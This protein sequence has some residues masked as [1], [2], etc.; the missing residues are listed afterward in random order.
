MISVVVSRKAVIEK[1][2][3]HL[4]TQA[5]DAATQVDLH[6]DRWFSLMEVQAQSPLT[7]DTAQGALNRAKFLA[8][9][10]RKMGVEA[11]HF[12]D[13]NGRGMWED[14][15]IYDDTEEPY[16]KTA[17]E[18][19][20][21]ITEPYVNNVGDFV[22]CMAV[23]VRDE[24]GRVVGMLVAEHS[25]YRLWDFIEDIRVGV[26]GSA[27]M[28]GRT[29]V[30]I[31]DVD[32]ALVLSQ[33]AVREIAKTDPDY[34]ALDQL[35]R[36]AL[37]STTPGVGG[38]SWAGV[39]YLV[40]YAQIP[41]TGWGL[42]LLAEIDDF[43]D[44]IALMRRLYIALALIS[45]AVVIGISYFVSARISRPLAL[46]V[47][48][49][50]R[51]A[52]EDLGV[53]VNAIR[54]RRDEFGTLGKA[55]TEMVTQ[56]G[57]VIDEIRENSSAIS[58]VGEKM[59]ST[60]A[61]LSDGAMQEASSSEEISATVTQLLATVGANSEAAI[62]AK[63]MA[64][65][66]Q[67]SIQRVLNVSEKAN[68]SNE[69]VCRRI[70]AIEDIARQTNILALNAAVE[71]ARAGEYGRGFAVVAG[72][73]RKLAEQSHNIANEVVGIAAESSRVSSEASK[74]LELAAPEV[75]N[76]SN[77][78]QK[79]A[80]ACLEQQNGIEQISKT[81]QQL[82]KLVQSNANIS[83]ALAEASRKLLE[84]GKRL[85]GLIEYFHR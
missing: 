66:A 84:Y 82:D 19:K 25:G 49:V 58:E 85:R 2:E 71:A 15:T 76:T 51:M 38:A 9:Q 77:L 57:S 5:Q 1:V 78:V 81:I 42:I 80:H 41:S 7:L 23:P 37:A 50:E 55:L 43:L 45:L 16:F 61:E 31:A 28:V 70:G 56:L 27:Y 12:A 59:D 44:T 13:A 21:A 68:S 35:E 29:G 69:L 3:A 32:S 74:D 60:S 52:K 24:A 10:G 48:A 4:T 39:P 30:T 36:K 67:A 22:F 20:R 72:E 34:I 6:L 33:E 14:G 54:V 63:E 40:S 46:T 79:I 53:E 83:V 26:D 75:I 47:S 17:M 65:G 18:G 62:R 73:V 8:K 64:V 11:L